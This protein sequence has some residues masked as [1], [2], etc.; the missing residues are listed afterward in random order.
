MIRDKEV[1]SNQGNAFT[2][3]LGIRAA[4]EVADTQIM[5]RCDATLLPNTEFDLHKTELHNSILT[6]VKRSESPT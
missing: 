6:K 4:S 2:V 5:Y 1:T 3:I